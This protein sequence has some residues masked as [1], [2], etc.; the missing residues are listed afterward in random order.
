MRP[1]T[2]ERGIIL[3]KL[4]AHKPEISES[5]INFPVVLV[6]AKHDVEH[7]VVF[8]QS[9]LHFPHVPL[10]M[11]WLGRGK[12]TIFSLSIFHVL[13][14]EDVGIPEPEI[15]DVDK[16]SSWETDKGIVELFYCPI[17]VSVPVTECDNRSCHS[18]FLLS[19]T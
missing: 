10:E 19:I 3:P 16:P 5:L 2:E 18:G 1:C 12:H 4:V 6:V 13:L 14:G 17:F 9:F 11:L 8:R 15:T 7:L